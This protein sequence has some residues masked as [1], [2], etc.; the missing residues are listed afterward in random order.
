MKIF[1]GFLFILTAAFSAEK[2]LDPI[3]NIPEKNFFNAHH[4]TDVQRGFLTAYNSWKSTTIL[5]WDIDQQ[6]KERASDTLKF[7]LQLGRYTSRKSHD[8]YQNNLARAIIFAVAGH[9][10]P[11]KGSTYLD[12]EVHREY[13]GAVMN[14]CNIL[15]ITKD[16]IIDL[17][18]GNLN[19]EREPAHFDAFSRIVLTTQERKNTEF[20]IAEKSQSFISRLFSK[21]LT[22][23]LDEALESS[24]IDF[25]RLDAH[26]ATES[27]LKRA[28]DFTY[29]VYAQHIQD[30]SEV[31]PNTLRG[32]LGTPPSGGFGSYT[33]PRSAPA[34][35]GA[36]AGLASPASETDA[37]RPRSA[38][39]LL[40]GSLGSFLSPTPPSRP[41]A[42]SLS[43][44]SPKPAHPSSM[45]GGSTSRALR[46][47]SCVLDDSALFTSAV[48][49]EDG[50]GEK[51]QDEGK[52]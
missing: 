29:S 11:I 31:N 30:K 5:R 21:P 8:S 7:V 2:F 26:A 19:I 22:H 12:D 24:L 39:V 6:F 36:S 49:E 28:M 46:A 41:V 33:S 44:S 52:A 40:L 43:F 4:R 45:H 35:Y 1:I 14:A 18:N 23:K 37:G 20:Q 15:R 50:D 27:R 13:V 25:W 10:W 34:R 9:V 38:S 47:S 3:L 42:R 16:D 51:K 17:A 32:Y 48:V